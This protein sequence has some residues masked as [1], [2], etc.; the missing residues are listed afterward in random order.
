MRAS[1]E[2]DVPPD[3]VVTDSLLCTVEV[4]EPDPL[5]STVAA[6]AATSGRP[7]AV[8]LWTSF[9]LA[10]VALGF[11]WDAA[12]SP[13][14]VPPPTPPLPLTPPPFCNCQLTSST[15]RNCFSRSRYCMYS[16]TSL[17]PA[18][19]THSGSTARGHRS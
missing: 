19:S 17:W 18:P 3:G 2:A 4:D 15:V 11:A 7:F 1:V 5:G 16:S 12:A 13:P 6:A 14:P 10:G 8:W 9:V